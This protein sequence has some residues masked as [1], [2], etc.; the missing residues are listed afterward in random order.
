VI[1]DGRNAS[2]LEYTALHVER[3]AGKA[4]PAAAFTRELS[5]GDAATWRAIAKG[6]IKDMK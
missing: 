6:M 5:R 1:P 2:H 3:F 4:P